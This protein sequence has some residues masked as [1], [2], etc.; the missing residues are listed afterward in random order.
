MPVRW[1][2]PGRGLGNGRS[3]RRNVKEGRAKRRRSA[4]GLDLADGNTDGFA[5]R[6]GVQGQGTGMRGE[7]QG[8][9]KKEG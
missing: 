4:Q 6:C 8:G 2:A 1:L 7:R 9:D 3:H 5:L